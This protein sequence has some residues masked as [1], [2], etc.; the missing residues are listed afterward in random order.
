MEILNSTQMEQADKYTIETL[1]I[2]S[3]VLME[4]ASKSVFDVFEELDLKS[5]KIAVVIGSGNNGGDGLAVSRILINNY[6]DVDIILT[7][8]PEKFKADAKTNYKILLNYGV[9]FIRIEENYDFSKYDV[10]FDA[11]FGT[12]LS[13]KIEGRYKTIVESINNSQAYIISIDIPSGLNG[14]TNKQLGISIKA[15]TTVTFCRPKIPH[16]LYPAKEYCGNVFVTDI[17]I[18]DISVEKQDSQIFLI[19]EENLPEIKHRKQDSHKGTYG[20]S[21]II[22]GSKGKSGA[23][24]MASK[25][26]TTIG[27]GLTTAILPKA[28][29]TAY[30]ISF[31][32]GMSFQLEGEYLDNKH[33]DRVLDFIKDKTVIAVGPGIGTNS[34]TKTFVK[35]LLKNVQQP[36]ILDADAINCLEIGSFK[37]F[38]SKT[39]LTPH[40]GEFARL[41]NITTDEL[42]N[43]RIELLKNFTVKNNVFVILKSSDTLIATPKGEIYVSSF[44]NPALSKGGSGDC[45]TGIISGLISQGYEILDACKLSCYFLGKT[46]EILSEE[47]HINTINTTDIIQNLWQSLKYLENIQKELI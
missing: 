33:I 21:I 47:K 28:I 42:K 40:I 13:R 1:E 9:N 41:L 24:I 37:Y 19:T 45:L 17:S 46:A 39:I 6:Y 27:A 34:E 22:G 29:S 43:N 8:D 44:G 18:P 3:I 10:I 25:A 36:I 30:E 5:E 32:E 2:P 35:E 4:N 16:C 26:C 23:V 7:S 31:L 20:H 11:I 14:N 12:G 38:K 15:D